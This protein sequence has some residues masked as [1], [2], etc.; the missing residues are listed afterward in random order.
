MHRGRLQ[1][2]LVRHRRQQA[3]K[4]R[5]QHAFA[6][7][8]RAKQ[9]DRMAAGGRDLERAFHMQLTLHVGKV[10]IARRLHGRVPAVARQPRIFFAGGEVGAHLQ[11]RVGRVDAGV[12]NECGLVGVCLRQDEGAAAAGTAALN[13]EGHGER[14]AHRPQLA[15]QRQFAGEFILVEFLRRDLAGRGQDAQRHR[16]CGME[17]RWYRAAECAPTKR[18]KSIVYGDELNFD[19]R[20]LLVECIPTG[21]KR[22]FYLD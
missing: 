18:N 17:N 22:A 14:A 21:A 5:S 9:Q 7:A 13:R 12:G 2:L 19:R 3:G 6:G 10:G 20:H 1:R 8:R 16:L 4:A 15:R 11:Q